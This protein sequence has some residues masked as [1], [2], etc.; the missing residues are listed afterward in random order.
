MTLDIAAEFSSF[1]RTKVKA[2]AFTDS[3][4][5]DQTVRRNQKLSSWF[6]ENAINWVTSDKPVSVVRGVHLLYFRCV[7]ATLHLELS[8]ARKVGPS[9]GQISCS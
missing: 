5:G 8:V 2:V 7:H 6:A 3:V 1:W 9:V 4:H